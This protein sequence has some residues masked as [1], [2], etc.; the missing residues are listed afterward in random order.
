MRSNAYFLWRQYFVP[1]HPSVKKLY[2]IHEKNHGI[3]L[4]VVKHKHA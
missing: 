3:V 1:L 4:I 2:A